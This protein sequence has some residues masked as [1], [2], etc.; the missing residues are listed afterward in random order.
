MGFFLFILLVFLFLALA[1]VGSVLTFFV[2]IFSFGRKN[3]PANSSETA[4]SATNSGGK[5]FTK[6][7]GEYVD[8]EEIKE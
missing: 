5:V 4:S 3:R 7:E 8:F 2:R 1:I 6:D